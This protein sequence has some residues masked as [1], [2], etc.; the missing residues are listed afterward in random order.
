MKTTFWAVFCALILA[1]FLC[2]FLAVQGCAWHKATYAGI[3]D[4]GK[5]YTIELSARRFA[6]GQD[7]Q[8]FSAQ[9]PGGYK[10][11][12]DSSK[13]DP[14]KVMENFFGVL[15]PVLQAYIGSQPKVPIPT[16]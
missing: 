7:V 4:H 9:F 15:G 11:G 10:V 13:G 14:T 5:P 2:A 1:A 8:G 12:F 16:R 6:M 3:D